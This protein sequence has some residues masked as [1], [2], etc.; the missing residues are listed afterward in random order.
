MFD[1]IQKRSVATEVFD[2]L[3][4]HIVAGTLPVG[5]ALPAERVLA[6]QLGVSRAAVREGLKRLEQAGLVSIQQGGAT[7]V[8]DYR[9]T[10]GLE[11]LSTLMIR[12]DGNID[13]GVVRGVIE[14]RAYL[15]PLV[16][17]QA[18]ARRDH[19]GIERLQGLL[20]AM[21]SAQGDVPALQQLALDFWEAMVACADNIALQLAFNSLVRTYG[22]VMEQTRQLVADEVTATDDY[23]RAIAAVIE[24]DPA[25]AAA[26]ARD[27]L[28]R[29]T[30]AFTQLLTLLDA[31]P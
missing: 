12:P 5:E 14:L 7:R 26:A 16:A 2:Q 25:A 27:I 11:L 9:Q 1:S 13:T 24:G 22:G 15:G 18:A 21:R 3:R 29:G 31:Q 28:A 10:G 4:G 23:D 20:A 6:E 19:A 17:E 30:T 8:L